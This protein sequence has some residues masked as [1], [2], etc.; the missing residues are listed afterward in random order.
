MS[1]KINELNDLFREMEKRLPM[2]VGCWDLGRMLSYINGYTHFK[3]IDKQFTEKEQHYFDNFYPW[4]LNYYNIDISSN[5]VS[6]LEG[7][8]KFHSGLCPKENVKHF[9]H[10]YK[11][12]YH[13]E[14]GEDAW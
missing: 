4:L 12:W 6:G 11:Q 13:E 1:L 8:I 14:F 10:L 7:I 9:F 5:T 2:Y 3:T